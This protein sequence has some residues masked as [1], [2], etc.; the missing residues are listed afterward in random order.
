MT[1]TLYQNHVTKLQQAE[2][3]MKDTKNISERV[4]LDPKT[5]GKGR[6]GQQVRDLGEIVS[7]KVHY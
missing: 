1:K 3:L 7:K 6:K 4:L 5:L 2:L